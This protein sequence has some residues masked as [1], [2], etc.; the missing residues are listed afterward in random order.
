MT[1]HPP[2][3]A[4]ARVIKNKLGNMEQY[5][6][7]DWIKL[8]AR[9]YTHKEYA[10]HIYIYKYIYIRIWYILRHKRKYFNHYI[11][12]QSH[13]RHFF[14]LKFEVGA[15][16]MYMYIFAILYMC[17]CCGD[18][19]VTCCMRQQSHFMSNII[20]WGAKK[21]QLYERVLSIC[22]KMPEVYGLIMKQCCK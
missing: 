2:H 22:G 17:Q 1:H 19:G 11:P 14:S 7:L 8:S 4:A 12:S 5:Y 13:F 6:F 18:S 21:R 20:L 9:T 16:S 10:T 15:K 3:V